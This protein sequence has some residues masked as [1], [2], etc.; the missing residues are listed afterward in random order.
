[1]GL[2]R[3]LVDPENMLAT[4]NVSTKINSYIIIFSVKTLKD[5]YALSR[6]WFLFILQKTEKTEFLG[7]FYKHCMHVLTAPL[8]ANTTEE[9]PSKGEPSGGFSTVF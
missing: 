4:A 5:Q 9:K 2:L 1:M 3:T 8:L 6:N 7:F